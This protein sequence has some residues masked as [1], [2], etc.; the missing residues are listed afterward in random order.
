MNDRDLFLEITATA[1][2]CTNIKFTYQHV[3]GHQ[4]D[5]PHR[6]LTIPEQ[7]NV[8]CDRRAKKFVTS[9]AVLSTAM[10]HPAL[11]AAQ[12]HL[13]IDGHVI[14]REYLSTIR[15]AAATPDYYEYLRKRFNWTTA[16]LRKIQWTSLKRAI[17]LFNRNDQRR[18]VLFIHDKLPLRSSKFHPH[19]GSTL[20]PSCRR[21]PEDYWHFLECHQTDRSKLFENLKRNLRDI[22]NKHQLHPSILTVFWLGLIAIRN[23]TPY[24][25]IQEDLPPSLRMVYSDQ[26]RI[27]W[28]QLYH[29]RLANTWATA[30]DQLN[31][32]LPTT[33]QQITIYMI[34]AVWN[35]ILESWGLRNQ[36][37]H[38]DGGQLSMPNYQ[39]AVTNL[40]ECRQQFPPT[41]QE[42]LFRRPLQ[43]MLQLP[44]A[45]LRT[46]LER[47]HLYVKQ[48]L[49]AA[50]TRAILNTPDIHSYFKLTTQTANDLQPP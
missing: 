43:E 32:S 37:L 48:Q 42:A 8:D 26:T 35:Y 49:K 11:P 33:G 24:P 34:Q 6:I 31:P 36:H 1:L 27:G 39:Q 29:G 28:D 13:I 19:L 38:Q 16:D 18:L 50:K 10:Q 22:S 46:W 23:D 40:C 17:Q 2:H 45:A 21:E 5:D 3:K 14:C 12:P 44:P 7:H 20:C 15:Q 4:D 41:T 30:I 25:D 9:S 47:S